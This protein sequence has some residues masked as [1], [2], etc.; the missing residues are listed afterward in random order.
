M[1]N[2]Q[3]EILQFELSPLAKAGV[4]VMNME[5]GA[6]VE[7]HDTKT[8]HRD[9]HYLLMLATHGQ[10]KLNLDFELLEI[11]APAML[12]V[13]PGQVHEVLEMEQPQGWA[14][15]FDPALIDGEFQQILEKELQGPMALQPDTDFYRQL[16]SLMQLLESQQS[17]QQDAYTGRATHGLLTA[18]LGWIAGRITSVAAD[19]K[20]KESRGTLIVQSFNGLL[21]QHYKT[22]K[23]P[24]RY[25]AELAISVAHLNDMVKTG[26]GMPVSVHIRQQSVLEAKRLL[27]FTDLSVR[28]IGYELGYEEPVYFG[29]LFRKTTGITPLQF[30]QQFRD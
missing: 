13:F 27:C 19:H 10:F 2:P 26:T 29:K 12:F 22:W 28:E 7:Q 3:P 16:V 5:N 30:R 21:K 24:A 14:V 25:A 11:V 6:A 8:P 1:K 18:L 15:S 23:Q 4:L 20:T 17:G 9:D